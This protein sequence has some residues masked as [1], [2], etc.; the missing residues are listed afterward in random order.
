MCVCTPSSDAMWCPQCAEYM[1][2]YGLPGAPAKF[3]SPVAPPTPFQAET[4]TVLIEELAEIQQEALMLAISKQ[5]ARAIQRGTKMLRFGVEQVQAEQD[6]TNAD[7]LSREI[8]QLFAVIGMA[9]RAGV[10]NKDEIAAGEEEKIGKL[11]KYMQTT[12]E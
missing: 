3:K 7:R 2:V 6:K 8:G 5:C 9:M 4:I 10:L 12:Q 1:V 11:E